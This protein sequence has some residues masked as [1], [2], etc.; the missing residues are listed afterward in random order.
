MAHP[1]T[2]NTSD[3]SDLERRDRN[4]NTSLRTL[5]LNSPKERQG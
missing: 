5:I 1:K 4:D 3:Y 2:P